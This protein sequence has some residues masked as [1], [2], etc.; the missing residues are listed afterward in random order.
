MT[1]SMQSS[2]LTFKLWNLKTVHNLQ[3]LDD[4]ISELI[5]LV[6]GMVFLPVHLPPC[7]I[8]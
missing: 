5:G 7:A 3:Q 2:T 4:T 1:L 6:Y 8:L